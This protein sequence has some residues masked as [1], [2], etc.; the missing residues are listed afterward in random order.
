MSDELQRA[1]GEITARLAQL[2]RRMAQADERW[3]AV[4][5]GALGLLSFV[6]GL[7]LKEKGL[8]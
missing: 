1:I 2:E 6:A 7:Y 5:Y 8:F 4:I 3:K